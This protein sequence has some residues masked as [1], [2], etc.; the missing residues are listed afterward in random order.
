MG[1]QYASIHAQTHDREKTTFTLRTLD[2]DISKKQGNFALE[3][4]GI[5]L[6]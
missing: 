4:H 5:E 2:R 3:C 6:L 1:C